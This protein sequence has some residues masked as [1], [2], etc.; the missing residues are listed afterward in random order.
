[1]LALDRVPFV[2]LLQIVGDLVDGELQRELR[3][4]PLGDLLRTQAQAEVAVLQPQ[5]AHEP[6]VALGVG[7]RGIGQDRLGAEPDGLE[8]VNRSGRGSVVA[9]GLDERAVK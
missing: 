3:L 5:D 2:Q 4:P 1:M 9:R 6:S 8:P 7:D